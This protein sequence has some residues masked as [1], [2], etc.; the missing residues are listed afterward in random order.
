MEMI[1]V[2]E[3]LMVQLGT[4]YKV[5]SLALFFHG[6]D[7]SVPGV[8]G[9]HASNRII[10]KVHQSAVGDRQRFVIATGDG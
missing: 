2:A 10:R 8:Q 6:T 9:T 7:I 1:P 5:D 4:K 3:D